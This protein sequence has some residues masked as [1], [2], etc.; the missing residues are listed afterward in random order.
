[1][2]SREQVQKSRQQFTN[3]VAQVQA[4][5][6]QAVQQ[7]EAA[8]QQE[9]ASREGAGRSRLFS[10]CWFS[11][12][13]SHVERDASR[14]SLQKLFFTRSMLT[15]FVPCKYS[16]MPQNTS[17]ARVGNFTKRVQVRCAQWMMRTL[18]H[19]IRIELKTSCLRRMSLSCLL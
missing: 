12:Q 10:F 3:V 18:F 16:N 7:Q 11:R 9:A 5:T 2:H 17:I 19:M 4:L 1:M 6:H 15:S 8:L 14:A 13:M